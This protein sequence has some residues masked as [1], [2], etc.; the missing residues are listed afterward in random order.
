M[1][2]RAD[3]TYQQGV[4]RMFLR[5]TKYDFYWPALA[6]IGEQAV[7]VMEL[8]A[9]DPTQDT[10][11]TGTPDNERVF[12]YQ[13]RYAEYRYK[14][15]LITG[16]LRSTYSTPLDVWHL[17]QKFTAL[18]TLGKTFIESAVP[19]ARVSAVAAESHFIV[20][21]YIDVRCARPMPVYS[22]PGL[23]DHF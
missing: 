15:G 7:T 8:Y 23:I 22:V 20:D 21:S 9:Q 19:M 13:E 1:N 3:L 6:Y 4:N 2:I 17:A 10:G 18:P 16:K 5:Q 11:S 14:P 12:G